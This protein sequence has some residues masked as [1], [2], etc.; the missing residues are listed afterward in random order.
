VLRFWRNP[1][2]VRHTRAE[3]RST[4]AVMVAVIVLL[5]CAMIGLACWSER[6]TILANA[7]YSAQHY[8]GEWT[9]YAAKLR[10][11]NGSQTW[12]LLCKWLFG[13]QGG[14]LTLWSLFACAQSVAGE[15][16]RK[17]WDFQRTTSLTPAEILIGKLVGEPVVVYFG[18]LCAL[19]ITL[20]AG[21]AGGLSIWMLLAA[22]VSIL[23]GALFL[24]LCGLWLSTLLESRSRGV[25]LIAGLGVYGFT[26]G[27]FG[28]ATSWF[29]G[30]AAF[31]PLTGLHAVLELSFNE[32]KDVTPVLFG[33]SVPWLWIS[34]LL[35]GSF[36]AW[37]VLMLVRNL[38]RDY[39]EIR[40]LSR[41]QAVGC[42]AFLNFVFYALFR[43]PKVVA[44][45]GY[46]L[47][48][49][50]IAT[51]MV[52]IN[53]MIL[54][55]IGLAS[56]TPHE[57]LKVWWRNRSEGIISLFSE[58]GLPW[59]WLA[60]SS[61]VAYG[62]LVWGLLSW[63]LSL[64]FQTR[65]FGT[66]AAQLLVVLVF[67][68]RDILFIQWCTLTRMRQPVVKGFFLL[69]LYYAAAGVVTA[70]ASISGETAAVAALS[71]LTP[72]G[73][74]NPQIEWLHFPA[75]IYEGLALQAGLIAVIVVG[76]SNRLGRVGLVAP[77]GD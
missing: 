12:L 76:I 56:L 45:V 70:I 21:L 10:T 1:E 42:A 38:K 36:G 73:A 63:R 61:L 77:S 6:Q 22:Y 41:W 50:L 67:I 34:L 37:I 64:D 8:D 20:A 26:V 19:P 5:V 15:R 25:G 16:D 33:H 14:L 69:A 62:L 55:A 68:T 71:I 75:S 57:R 66:A 27:T 48:S 32:R 18:V 52:G 2:F 74:F 28:F 3:L 35:Y 39:E 40:P 46:T 31:S 9:A 44:D 17:T 65:T 29:P 7:E 51:F 24:G 60:L 49:R 23:V 59:P 4:R 11:E 30:L 47:D 58:D 72:V 13:L 43:A 54:F 53:G